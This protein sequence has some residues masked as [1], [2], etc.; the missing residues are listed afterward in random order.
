MR[1]LGG[2][3]PIESVLW[4]FLERPVPLGQELIR[5][6]LVVA[7]KEPTHPTISGVLNEAVS[8][9]RK[10]VTPQLC[11]FFG[12]L[13]IPRRIRQEIAAL[14]QK[15]HKEQIVPLNICVSDMFETRPRM[16]CDVVEIPCER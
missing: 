12:V 10:F 14:R 16:P 15:L 11:L 3:G 4:Q 13:C 7:L 6:S 2:L 5:F 8:L 9:R 1:L